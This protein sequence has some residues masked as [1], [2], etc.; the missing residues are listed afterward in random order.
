MVRWTLRDTPP[1]A[2]MEDPDIY[3]ARQ[4]MT[5]PHRLPS[6]AAFLL[7]VAVAVAAAVATGEDRADPAEF[8][9]PRDGQ[10]YPTVEIAGMT[11]FARNL[12]F[13]APHSWCYE[14]KKENCARYGR[15]YRWESALSACSAGWHLSTE[16]E[17]QAMEL[18]IG[19]SFAELADRENRGTKQG[20]RLKLHGDTGFDAQYGGWRRSED[21]GYEA[22]GKNAALWL[23]TES[24]LEHAWHRDIDTGDDMIYRSQVIKPYGLSVRCVKNRHDRDEAP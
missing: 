7:V 2:A 11:W 17:W 23:A 24:D 5:H 1:R 4:P 8:E 9:D 10:K 6:A 12:N 20:A 22:A 15:L 14:E 3:E 16:Y 13:D 18:A 19:L 21:G